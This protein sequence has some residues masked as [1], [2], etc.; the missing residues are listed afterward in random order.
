MPAGFY[1][2]RFHK[3]AWVWPLAQK[4]L[5]RLAGVGRIDPDMPGGLY[6]N[7]H[8]NAE[9][10]VLGG[11]SAGLAAAL[12]AARTGVRVLLSTTATAIY[13]SNHVTAVQRGGPDDPFR[14][15]ACEIR[16]KGVV[17]ASGAIERPLIFRNNDLPGIMQGS[18]A[19]QLV[20]TYGLAPGKRAVISGCHDGLL[21]VAHDLA[22]AGVHVAAVAEARKERSTLQGL[23]P[24]KS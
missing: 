24:G 2:K 5:R 21:E 7:R 3:P 13:Q 15:C 9:V 22:E 11:G 8:L 20:H 12:A 17:V 4:A 10:C 18:C 16:A 1:Y 6:E 23:G 19:Q 14:L